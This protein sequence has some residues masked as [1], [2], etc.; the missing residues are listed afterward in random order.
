MAQFT[1]GGTREILSSKVHVVVH[2]VVVCTLLCPPSL[3]SPFSFLPLLFP[4]SPLSSPFTRQTYLTI[5]INISLYTRIFICIQL[6]SADHWNQRYCYKVES[7]MKWQFLLFSG[8]FSIVTL[9]DIDM[10]H[11]EISFRQDGG[12]GG[13][14]K[15]GAGCIVTREREEREREGSHHHNRATGI[16]PHFHINLLLT[17]T[18]DYIFPFYRSLRG[19]PS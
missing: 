15:V 19:L 18:T 11:G 6:V 4:P 2:H 3:S 16:L 17:L 1:V 12:T 5:Y 7:R 10:H 8:H 14:M 13:F 9:H